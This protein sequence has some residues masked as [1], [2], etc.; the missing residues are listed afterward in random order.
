M[1]SLVVALN[2]TAEQA[3]ASGKPLAGRL[4]MIADQVR[5]LSPPFA[6]AVDQFVGR[7]VA[8]EAGSQTPPVGEAM[9]AFM[10]P[11]QQGRLVSLQS[12]LTTGPLV[13]VFLRGH[14]CPYCSITA[15]AIAEISDEVTR[16]GARVVAITPE[17]RKYADRFGA[18]YP[19]LSD[20][21]NGYALSINLAVW[22]D[23]SMADLIASAGWDVPTYQGNPSWIL[24][25]PAVFVLSK[26]G[27]VVAKHVNPD[28]RVR[29]DL[30]EVIASLRQLA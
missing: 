8:A 25:I 16:L 2:E 29:A 6:E 26:E 17:R 30:D 9:P 15:A 7:L 12:L 20:I 1:N 18:D 4:R 10:L 14:W 3:K 22:V 23:E 28:Y 19:M 27:V 13:I 24:P 5:D 11:D 21:D